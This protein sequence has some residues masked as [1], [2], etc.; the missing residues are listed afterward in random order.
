GRGGPGMTPNVDSQK[1]VGIPSNQTSI[2]SNQNGLQNQSAL[3]N[4]P[5]TLH[6]AKMSRSQLIEII[7]ELKG[8]ATHNKEMSR[9]LLLSRPQLPKALFQV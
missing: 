6:L 2:Q 1:Q 7:S 5:L 4:D 8:M 3:A 9:Q